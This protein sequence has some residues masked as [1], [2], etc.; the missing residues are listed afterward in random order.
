MNAQNFIMV[1]NIDEGSEAGLT[2]RQGD[3]ERRIDV[4]SNTNVRQCRTMM[5]DL[6]TN[7]EL[8]MMPPRQM[9]DLFKK[10]DTTI[11][12]CIE[13]GVIEPGDE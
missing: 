7:E 5:I 8:Q 1:D 10:Q 2:R 11:S 13:V 4:E 12:D 9:T 6:D 3:F